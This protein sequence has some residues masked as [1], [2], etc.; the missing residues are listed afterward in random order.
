M[1]GQDAEM[2]P[3]TVVWIASMTKA[4]TGAVAM[5]QVERGFA[6]VDPGDAA[7]G[8]RPDCCGLSRAPPGISI[9]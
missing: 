3:D 4:I 1:L 6:V 9:A 2:T 8:I 7:A 5:Q